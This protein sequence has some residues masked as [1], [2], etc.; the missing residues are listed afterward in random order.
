MGA[1]LLSQPAALGPLPQSLR[2]PR[3]QF[4]NHPTPSLLTPPPI[5]SA[6]MRLRPKKEIQNTAN[7]YL[8]IRIWGFAY[9]LIFVC[10]PQVNARGAFGV[11]CRHAQSLGKCESPSCPVPIPGG[12]SSSAFLSPTHT[13]NRVPF[14]ILFSAMRFPLGAFSW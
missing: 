12:T 7:H 5:N 1:G 11:L 9:L 8:W 4:E 6:I 10:N 2:V 13:G 14:Y 3:V